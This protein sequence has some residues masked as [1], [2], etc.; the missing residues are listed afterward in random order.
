MPWRACICQ[1]RP[2]PYLQLRGLCPQSAIDTLFLPVN[3][4]DDVTVLHYV[5]N[6]DSVIRYKD[7]QWVLTLAD[8]STNTSA[9]TEA[10][11]V[12]FLLGKHQWTVHNDSYECSNGGSYTTQ[13]KLTTCKEG[14]FTCRD[15]QCVKMDQRCNQLPDCR[16]E[17]DES[18]CE[19]VVLKDGY[20]QKIP[21]I[22]TASGA[23]VPVAVNVSITLL[24]VVSIVEV[25]HSIQ[26]QF[27]INLDW[28][29]NR[30]KLSW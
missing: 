29:D 19:L 8:S 20:N 24:K 1:T 14:D 4:R 16:D 17:S 3:S 23:L 10:S 25:E 21:P 22:T 28:R 7:D 2:R 18:S 5:S 30:L 12:S 27:E 6:R 9:V 15:G 11:L 26:L 13:L